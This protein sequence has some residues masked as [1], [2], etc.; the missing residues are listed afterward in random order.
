MASRL[1]HYCA[2]NLKGMRM[3]ADVV[4]ELPIEI[5][6]MLDNK[7]YSRMIILHKTQHSG[8]FFSIFF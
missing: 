4:M 3:D 6:Q 1:D 8:Q 2:M 5:M 7:Q